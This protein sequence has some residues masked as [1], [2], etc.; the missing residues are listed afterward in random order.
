MNELDGQDC[1]ASRV[2]RIAWVLLS[3][4]FQLIGA[5]RS[6]DLNQTVIMMQF[7]LSIGREQA[8][9]TRAIESLTNHLPLTTTPQVNQDRSTPVSDH[10]ANGTRNGSSDSSSSGQ[11]MSIMN[12]M[13]DPPPKPTSPSPSTH[14]GS[15]IISTTSEIPATFPFQKEN[16]N[17]QTSQI[18]TSALQQPS[19]LSD[20]S[21]STPIPD[22]STLSHSNGSQARTY[23]SAIPSS[24]PDESF[25]SFSQNGPTAILTNGSDQLP[26]SAVSS[27]TSGIQPKLVRAPRGGKSL[28][29]ATLPSSSRSTKSKGSK[30]SGSGAMNPP[31]KRKRTDLREDDG[32]TSDLED[33][34]NQATFSTEIELY[35]QSLANRYL[36]L[37]EEYKAQL[38]SGAST[39]LCSQQSIE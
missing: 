30:A 5:L 33:P 15:S 14:N 36:I 7:K 23:G 21:I 38:R 31:S 20:T 1:R 39:G 27:P 8:F 3:H 24:D 26:P 19:T 25:P 22:A 35:K 17:T 4:N 10:A 18:S 6:L 32:W 16:P 28:P 11:R 12:I 2:L 34:A 9:S 29:T 37:E 13:N